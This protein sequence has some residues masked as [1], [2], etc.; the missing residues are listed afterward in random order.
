[1]KKVLIIAYYFPPMGLSGV[2]RT[3]KFAKYL[4]S[5]HWKPTV[6]TVAP[7]GYLAKD[8]SLLQEAEESEVEVVR[9]KTLDPTRLFRK[10]N[11]VSLPPE[12]VRKTLNRISQVF[13]IPD[14]KIGWKSRARKTAEHLLR[15]EKFDIIFATAPPYTDFLIGVELKKKFNIPL[16]LDYRDAWVDYPY[17]FYLTPIHRW[18]HVRFER[19]VL[20]SSD[21]VVVVN[22]RIKELLLRRYPFLRYDDIVTISQGFDPADF[23]FEP[24]TQLP[25][26]NRMRFTYSGTFI[27]D[28][29]PKY[30]LRALRKVLD[31]HPRLRGRIEACFI[32]HFRNENL[33]IV[34]RLGLEKDVK[35]IKYLDHRES[36]KY[37]LASDV[38]WLMI[39]KGKGMDTRST[40]KLFEYIGA[41][42]PILGCVQDG[43]VKETILKSGAGV[44]VD[45]EDFVAM[46]AAIKDFYDQFEKRK[47]KSPDDNFV[48]NYDRVRLTA[49]LAKIFELLS[50]G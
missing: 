19:K 24:D 34:T 33:R 18:L 7:T 14:N 20:E 29:T 30:F 45:A 23:Q 21:K 3:L 41:R 4:P 36:V 37:L 12:F 42:K 2:Q 11:V 32:G 22:R 6:L 40:G 9:S 13:F 44:V 39:G 17:H 15:K 50:H 28:V 43:V 46:S 49:D 27:D 48:A 35:I 31:E 47:L 1:M 10:H 38:L 16:V 5:Y 25:K 8:L 26:S